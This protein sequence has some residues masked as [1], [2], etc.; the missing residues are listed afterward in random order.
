MSDR[1]PSIVELLNREGDASKSNSFSRSQRYW[2]GFIFTL[3]GDALV[4]ASV[5]APWIEI[6]KNDPTYLVPRQGY[7]PW[8]ALLR[9]QIDQMGALSGAYFLVA[10]GLL[11]ATVVLARARSANTRAPARDVAAGLVIIGLAL[12]GVAVTFIPMAL[13]LSSPYYDHDLVY[14][15]GLAAIGLLSALVG[16]IVLARPTRAA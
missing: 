3:A 8:L 12:V 4:V 7:S 14:G 16:A 15:G 5:F 1:D 9:G 10:L 11:I 2:V 13:S 6:Y